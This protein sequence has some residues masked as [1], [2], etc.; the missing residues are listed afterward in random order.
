[1]NRLN[2]FKKLAGYLTSLPLIALLM[3]KTVKSAELPNQFNKYHNYS[4]KYVVS[5]CFRLQ[6]LSDEQLKNGVKHLDISMIHVPCYSLYANNESELIKRLLQN[7]LMVIAKSKSELYN[8]DCEKEFK[9]LMD[10]YVLV[11]I[12]SHQAPCPYYYTLSPSKIK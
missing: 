4:P 1:M 6:E 7:N 10:K 5:T 9:D 3:P 12:V 8:L 11:N 2:F